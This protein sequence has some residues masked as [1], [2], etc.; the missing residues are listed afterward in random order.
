MYSFSENEVEAYN[1]NWD[2]QK[3]HDVARFGHVQRPSG[4]GDI[5]LVLRHSSQGTS[6][7]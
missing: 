1:D 7:K 4:F 3:N 6:K 2:D 5:G